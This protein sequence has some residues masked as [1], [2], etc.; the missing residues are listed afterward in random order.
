MHNPR[1]LRDRED[2]RNKKTQEKM[3]N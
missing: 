3:Q 1:K 2:D